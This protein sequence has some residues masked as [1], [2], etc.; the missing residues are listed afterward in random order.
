MPKTKGIIPP[1]SPQVM[2]EIIMNKSEMENPIPTRH[3]PANREKSFQLKTGGVQVFFEIL[4]LISVCFHR[5]A[6]KITIAENVM[7]TIGTR[8]II[9]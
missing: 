1:N 4:S 3:N 5:V 2:P 7:P 9:T 8:A 6:K